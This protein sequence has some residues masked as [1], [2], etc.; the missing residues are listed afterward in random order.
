MSSP[1]PCA[2]HPTM[3]TTHLRVARMKSEAQPA[4]PSPAPAWAFL[5]ATFF[6]VGRLQPGPGTWASLV[7]ILIWLG[8]GRGLSL[9]R[10]TGVLTGLVVIAVAAGIPAATRVARASKLKDPQFVVID[11]V[12]GQW[13]ALLLAPLSW[14]TLL[15]GFILFRV[16]DILKPPPVR[17]LERLR[18]GLG[19]V[20]DDVAAGV[21]AML[22]MQLLLHFKLL[23]R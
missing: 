13:I 20:V 14:K 3:P 4:A 2:I 1:P 19:I 21:Y 15:A 23:S 12:A 7:A 5:V 22:G 17:Q 9:A 16:F 6:G 10:Q 11:E 18:E 8:I